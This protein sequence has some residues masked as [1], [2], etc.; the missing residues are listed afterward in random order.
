MKYPFFS[1]FLTRDSYVYLDCD[2]SWNL[3]HVFQSGACEV[4]GSPMPGSKNQSL[5]NNHDFV[6]VS[7][8]IVT[9]ELWTNENNHTSWSRDGLLSSLYI[10][11]FTHLTCFSCYCGVNC[12]SIFFPLRVRFVFIAFLLYFLIFS[13]GFILFFSSWYLS[14]NCTIVII[15]Y[16]IPYFIFSMHVNCWLTTSL[17]SSG[18]S[19]HSRSSLSKA[20]IFNDSQKLNIAQFSSALH[21]FAH[22]SSLSAFCETYEN[23]YSQS[24]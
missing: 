14:W 4:S 21:A 3:Q 19:F 8:R 15:F 20:H 24:S 23:M 18:F 11:T 1:N 10:N 22:S 7:L 2:N 6:V 16:K 12:P 17:P 9:I 5:M 13:F